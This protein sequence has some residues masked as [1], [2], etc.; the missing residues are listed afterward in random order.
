MTA[1]ATAEQTKCP[2]MNFRS[3]VRVGRLTDRDDGPVTGYTADI[4]I[5]CADCKLPFRFRGLAAGYSPAEPKLSA[6]GLELRAPIEPAYT[7]EILG[8][9]LVSGTA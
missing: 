4:H 9:P 8:M 7:V 6:D 5:E 3:L 2:H 1:N